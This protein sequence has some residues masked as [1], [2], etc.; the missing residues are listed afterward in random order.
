MK[1]LGPFLLLLLLAAFPVAAQLFNIGA[2]KPP[3]TVFDNSHSPWQFTGLVPAIGYDNGGS[4]VG[5]NSLSQNPSCSANGSGYRADYIV[6]NFK[7]ST[8]SPPN[9]AIPYQIC[10]VVGDWYQY[11]I[12][13][14]GAGPFNLTLYTVN[15][16]GGA[17]W[18]V[19]IDGTQVATVVAQGNG[20]GFTT[21]LP[22]TSGQFALAPGNHLLR[23][24]ALSGDPINGLPGDLVQWQG[25]TQASI[26][27]ALGPNYAGSVPA[28]AAAAG[29]NTCA[30]NFDFTNPFFATLSNWLDCAGAATPIL[31]NSPGAGG[32]V[33]WDCSAYSIVNDGGTN[34]LLMRIPSGTVGIRAAVLNTVNDSHLA[35]Q[36]FPQTLYIEYGFRMA[37]QDQ[38]VCTVSLCDAMQFFHYPMY[39]PGANVPWWEWDY[40][41]VY[42]GT[43]NGLADG[44][45]VSHDNS[46]SGGFNSF[47]AE[48]NAT[49]VKLNSNFNTVLVADQTV[50]HNYAIRVV[51]DGAGSLDGSVPG[52]VAWCFYL[53]GAQ[54]ACNEGTYT[55]NAGSLQDAT[56]LREVIAYQNVIPA[57]LTL[58]GNQ[59]IYV[60]YYRVWECSG[61][62]P[63]GV[64]INGNTCLNT[65]ADVTG[66]LA[67][68]P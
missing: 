41:E 17:N 28:A 39:Y 8:L 47:L 18:A 7:S 67:G 36:L 34:A 53:D 54:K 12:S 23:L 5:Y 62:G 29:F 32:G 40:T 3:E 51:S 48:Y 59:D 52:H 15:P 2:L 38:S 49:G 33:G 30:A 11:T 35:G 1:R 6:G 24:T 50:Y 66:K 25:G 22:A 14:S 63:T 61:W 13:S 44:A 43:H 37:S 65:T 46:V 26:A 60:A 20:I 4:G 19:S 64:N 58:S 55:N 42:T 10:T 68:P 56:V 45:T 21:V 57:G 31:W 27:C 9:P 16:N